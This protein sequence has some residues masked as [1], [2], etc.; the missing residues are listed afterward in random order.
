VIPEDHLEAVLQ[1]FSLRR[2]LSVRLNTLKSQSNP[3]LEMLVQENIAFEPVVW[4]KDALIL[5]DGASQDLRKTDLIRLRLH[6]TD[7][8]LGSFISQ[9]YLYLQGLSSMLPA[10]VLN[11]QPGER[12]LDLC[13]APGSKTTQM[14]CLMQ[15]QGS[16][17]AVEPIRDRYYKLRSIVS[18]SGAKIVRFK[19]MDGR[20]LRVPPTERPFDKILVDAPCSCEGRFRIDEPKTYA[21]WS[22]RKIREMARKQKGLLLNA[23]R[24][25]KANGILV[26]STCSFAPEENEAV[27]D[28]FLRKTEG[29][30]R[31]LPISLKG[32]STYPVL[33]QWQDRPFHPEIR[34]GLRVLPD[35]QMEGFFMARLMRLS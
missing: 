31:P 12:V 4:Y 24:L 29:R 28:W 25:L 34:H 10:L 16:L 11:P 33:T 15:N 9:G 17:L 19:R 32:I 21:Y 18:Q 23:S 2:P 8:S 1:S 5:N 3:V 6:T 22:L 27:V 35:D 26:Y 13:A 30:F 20:R 7:V 14:V